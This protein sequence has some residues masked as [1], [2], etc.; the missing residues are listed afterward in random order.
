I[1]PPRLQA[2]DGRGPRRLPPEIP[3]RR[4]GFV[5]KNEFAAEKFILL[6]NNYRISSGKSYRQ[7][8]KNLHDPAM[9]FFEC[10]GARTPH[11]LKSGFL[12]MFSLASRQGIRYNKLS[13]AYKLRGRSD[14]GERTEHY[15]SEAD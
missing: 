11:K 9:S 4:S 5:I 1:F 14:N 6:W 3:Q 13:C 2:E 15:G 10:G 8:Q 12:A 7:S